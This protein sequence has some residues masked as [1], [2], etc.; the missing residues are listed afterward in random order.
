MAASVMAIPAYLR[1][2]PRMRV[3][4]STA[5]TM[6]ALTELESPSGLPI[7]TTGCPGS[8]ASES[9]S[10]TGTSTSSGPI[11][12][13][14]RDR[15]SS[16]EVLSTRAS[17]ERP[18][19]RLTSI[20]KSSPWVPSSSRAASTTCQLLRARPVSSMITP[21]PWPSILKPP[22]PPP[23]KG[24]KPLLLVSTALLTMTLIR[25]LR[26]FEATVSTAVGATSGASVRAALEP[27]P[28]NDP[29]K[30]AKTVERGA[31][32]P[33]KLSSSARSEMSGS[34]TTMPTRRPSGSTTAPPRWPGC[35][36]LASCTKPS[37]SAAESTPT[38]R[39]TAAW[40]GRATTAVKSPAAIFEES[41]ISAA[42]RVAPSGSSS[43]RRAVWL[44]AWRITTFAA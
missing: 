32:N 27:S 5:L 18:S 9:P 33:R 10:S 42:G 2:R 24:S 36:Q 8:S 13:E 1:S 43:W 23:P 25:E 40:K 15:S 34:S 7:A 38:L 20:L 21:E 3:S 19:G 17:K 12:S 35:T 30:A 26:V 39:L 31:A 44:S 14:S 4:T 6:P 28:L 11:C 22:A 41:S 16:R 37:R 29:S